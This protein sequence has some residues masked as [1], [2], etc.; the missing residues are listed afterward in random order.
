MR[1]VVASGSTWRWVAAG[2]A[3]TLGLGPAACATWESDLWDDDV[4]ADDDVSGD[5]DVADDDT[6]DDDIGDDVSGDDDTGDDDT[7]G[8]QPPT[9][10]LISISPPDPTADDDLLCTVIQDS[11]DPENDPISYSWQWAVDGVMIGFAGPNLTAGATEDGQFWSCAV[12]PNDG[13]QD[14]DAGLASVAIG[15]VEPFGY[16]VAMEFDASGGPSGGSATV[17]YEH[18]ML[19]ENFDPQ[20]SIRFEFGASYTYGTSQGTDYYQH[21]DEVLAWTSGGEIGSSCPITWTVYNSDPISEWMWERHPMGFVS[22]EQVG[23]VPSLAST[24]VGE[25]DAGNLPTTDGT[26]ADFCDNVGPAVENTMS[27]GPVEGIWLMPGSEGMLDS[28]GTWSYFAPPDTSNVQVYVLSGMA[29][30]L[31]SNTDEPV[32]GLQGEYAVIP[33]WLFVYNYN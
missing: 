17:Q 16:T 28:L 19:D 7:A 30:Q 24:Y 21:I 10:P 26:F 4:S 15:D 20:C 6:G 13:Q 27:T 25:D 14:G 18:V 23:A 9:A 33:F 31:P 32:P 8:N 29:M 2:L 22:C 11:T 5:D 1:T 3:L 12:I